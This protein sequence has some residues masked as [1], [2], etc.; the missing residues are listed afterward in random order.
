MTAALELDNFSY[1]R[2]RQRPAIMVDQVSTS[3]F[4][5]DMLVNPHRRPALSPL[6][7]CRQ[8]EIVTLTDPRVR[9][10]DP[11]EELA[12]ELDEKAKRMQANL[13]A[14]QFRIEALRADAELD[15]YGLNK[16]SEHDFWR[17]IRSD[18]FI[19]KGNIV[20]LENGNLR[21]TWKGEHGD[22]IGLQ[23]LG[24]RTVQ[25]VIFKW[26]TVAGVIS[27]VAGRDNIDSVKRQIAAFELRPLIYA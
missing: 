22:H 14:C 21:A 24:G 25:Y 12:N 15:G 6:A 7:S 19:R 3:A 20:L 2:S 27:R 4:N 11:S 16:A 5:L 13:Q 18:P 8:S 17:F 10:F 23:F 1:D 26:R 9:V